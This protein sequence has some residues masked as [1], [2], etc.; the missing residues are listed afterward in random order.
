MTISKRN[1]LLRFEA[2]LLVIAILL[3]LMSLGAMPT[4]AAGEIAPALSGTIWN[5]SGANPGVVA[6]MDVASDAALGADKAMVKSSQW[7]IDGQT[8]SVADLTV[9]NVA[10]IA[11]G[12]GKLYIYTPISGMAFVNEAVLPN[13]KAEVTVEIDSSVTAVGNDFMYYYADQCTLLTALGVPDTSKLTA[14]GENFMRNYANGCKSL[15]SLDAPNTSKLKAAKQWFLRNYANGCTS[16]TGLGV[17]DTSNLEGTET[18]FLQSYAEGCTSLKSLG[19]PDTSNIKTVKYAFMF[20]YAYRCR[21]LTSLDVPDASNITTAGNYFLASY[22]S[23]CTSLESLGVPDTSGLTSAGDRFM[24]SYASGSAALESLGV[25][26]T[27]SL[28]TVGDLFMSN[29]AEGCTSLTGLNTAGGPG[30]FA[31]NDVDWGVDINTGPNITFTAPAEHI[32]DWYALAS[33][34]GK[35]LYTNNIKKTTHKINTVGTAIVPSDEPDVLTGTATIDNTAPKIGD[36]L[37]A[38][39]EG[40]NNTGTLSYQWK[41][42]GVNAGT[43]ETNI[44]KTADLGETITVEITSSVETGAVVSEATSAVVKKPGPAAPA[45]PTSG[46][47]TSSSIT[48]TEIA[49]Y[50]YSRDGST[51][52]TSNVFSGL[53]ANTEYTF[54]QRVAETEDALPSPAS[55]M[56]VASTERG[57]LTPTYSISLSTGNYTFPGAAAGYGAQTA[58]TI[59]VTNTGNEPTGELTIAI[60]GAN[61]VAFDLSKTSIA[62]IAAGNDDSFAVTPK[63]GLAAGTYTATVTVSGENGITESFNV[64]FTVATAQSMTYIVIFNPNG[65]TVSNRIATTDT[66]GM[67]SSLPVPTRN[68]YTFNG[69]F[70]VAS[71]GIMITTNMVFKANTTVFAQWTAD[72]NGEETPSTTIIGGSEVTT[73]AGNDPVPNDDGSVTLPG[74]GTVITGGDKSVTVKAPDGTVVDKNGNVTIPENKYADVTTPYAEISVPGGSRIDSNGVITVGSGTADVVLPSGT[75]IRLREGSIIDGCVIIV[76]RGGA[77]IYAGGCPIEVGEGEVITLDASLPSGF[78]MRTGNPFIDVAGSDWFFNDV[79][80]V[81][82]NCLMVGTAENIFSPDAVVTRG[83]VVTVLWRMAG[84]PVPQSSGSFIDLTQEWYTNAALWAA[85]AGVAGGYGGG[86]F[87]PEDNIT[88]EDLAAMLYRYARWTGRNTAASN[89]LSGYADAGAIADYAWEAMAWA[90]AS[91]LIIGR[92]STEL[93]P[94]GAAT[95]A[96]LAAILHRFWSL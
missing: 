90:N 4:R 63:T 28:V 57:P 16:L 48:L 50:E 2:A 62:D 39:L 87:G 47:K 6:T 58:R 77:T 12:G 31:A 70:T 27:T 54:Y 18:A 81:Y 45:A 86:V 17:P 33:E 41:V 78:Y 61:P 96:E 52:Q 76:G 29:Y 65:G 40:G 11:A 84:R 21:S 25:P 49:G 95:R 5:W 19:V 55:D 22:A 82:Q 75:G 60:S 13:I 80:Y 68:G 26:D 32:D 10:S 59:T 79:M 1:P 94:K 8:W 14:A 51:W 37:T 42:G 71:G 83:M 46:N 24:G 67:L 92:S 73:P 34:S 56:L 7:S 93:A 91:G 15:K 35:T 44:V 43:G 38:T 66:N 64:S 72:D 36:T 85:E 20:F 3:S 30:Y 88:R 23:S 89:D 9:A 53:D 74:G 69:W